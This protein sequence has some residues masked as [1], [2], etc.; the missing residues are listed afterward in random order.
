MQGNEYNLSS[1]KLLPVVG[2]KWLNFFPMHSEVVVYGA[3]KFTVRKQAIQ[4]LFC[5]AL[6]FKPGSGRMGKGIVEYV[7]VDSDSHNG[8]LRACTWEILKI[9]EIWYCLRLKNPDQSV[10]FPDLSFF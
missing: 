7:S 6:C 9:G 3:Y 2:I 5:V 1:R 8:G 10:L 4:L